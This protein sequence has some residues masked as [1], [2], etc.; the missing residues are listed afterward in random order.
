MQ[1]QL[2]DNT[3]RD[4][5][6]TLEPAYLPVQEFPWIAVL[7]VAA[8]LAL[9]AVAVYIWRRRYRKPPRESLE[10]DARRRLQE[11]ATTDARVFHAELAAILTGYAEERLGLRGS[12]LTSAEIV[13]EFRTN[14]VMSAAWQESLAA[15]LRQCDHAK[16]APAREGEWDRSARLA[17]C[18]A[19]LDELAAA[20]AA[21]PRLAN[22]WERWTNAAV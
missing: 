4:I 15:F 17:E 20:A 16:F 13:R 5:L 10:Q 2:P 1:L 11:L 19:L 9:A 21:S 18:R 14:G 3:R 6:D 7:T 8:A 22:P 12:R